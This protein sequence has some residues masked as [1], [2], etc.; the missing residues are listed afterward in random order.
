VRFERDHDFGG[1]PERVGELMCDP[2]FQ[3]R[4]ELPDLSLPTVVGHDVDGPHRLLR[5]R[6]RYTGQLDSVARRVIGNRQLTWVQELR[7]DV[8]QGTGAL[9]FSADDDAG[10]V[11]GTA[12]VTISPT[13][14]DGAHRRIAGDFHIRIPLVGGTAERKIVPGLVRRLDVE[15]AALAARLASGA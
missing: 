14:E 7:L 4:V 2:E 9:S 10:R 13:K 11:G 6:Y 1:S 5:L 12:S 3:A 15:A 8:E